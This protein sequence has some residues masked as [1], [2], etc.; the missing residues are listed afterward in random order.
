[1]L[2][3]TRPV[4]NQFPTRRMLEAVL[5]ILKT[6]VEWDMLPQ[7]YPNYK[8][9]HRRFQTSC[10]NEVPCDG[11][12]DV[13]NEFRDKGARERHPSFFESLLERYVSLRTRVKSTAATS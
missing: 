7:S 3:T 13:A 1:M 11:P 9:V 6:G 4:A 2:P 8:T 10:S 5:W 12:A